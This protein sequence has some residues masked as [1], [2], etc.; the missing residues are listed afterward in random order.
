MC[1]ACTHKRLIFS[2]S[3]FLSLSLSLPLSLSLSLSSTILVHLFESQID[4]RREQI[5]DAA[6]VY[7]VI[8]TK[9]N[10]TRICSDCRSQLYNSYYL[11][12][13]TPISRDLLEDLAR[14]TLEASSVPLIS[15]VATPPNTF[16]GYCCTCMCVFMLHLSLWWLRFFFSLSLPLLSTD[17]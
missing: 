11:N 9:E 1:N 4:S 3:F 14:G 13:I 8:P 16:R 5:A 12:F 15:K 10:V 2:L 7:F 17:L 6:A